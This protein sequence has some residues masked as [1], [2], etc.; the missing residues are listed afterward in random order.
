MSS[1]F[2][3]PSIK[4]WSAVRNSIAVLTILRYHL[5]RLVNILKRS[6]EA[7]EETVYASFKNNLRL[8]IESHGMTIKQFCEDIGIPG[9]TISRYLSGDREPK[10]C[11]IIKIADYFNVSVDWLL[12]INGK[13]FDVLPADIQ[14]VVLLYSVASEDDRRVIRLLLNKYK[15]E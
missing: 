4:K 11:Y 10:V 3:L 13:K 8:L 9:A 6:Q 15:K 12:G 5:I 2:L 1:N 7:M 14:D